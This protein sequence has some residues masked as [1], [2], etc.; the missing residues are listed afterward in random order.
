[1]NRRMSTGNADVERPTRGRFKCRV[2][3]SG[4]AVLAGLALS[5]GVASAR[6]NQTPGNSPADGGYCS[7]AWQMADHSRQGWCA[8]AITGYYGNGR[9]ISGWQTGSDGTPPPGGGR[10]DQ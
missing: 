2:M 6:P 5:A 3:T 9:D 1:M 8:N 4:A 10:G 7:Q